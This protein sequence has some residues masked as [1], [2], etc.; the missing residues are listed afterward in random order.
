MAEFSMTI[1]AAAAATGAA[2]Q[3]S[4]RVVLLGIYFFLLFK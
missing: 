2:R 4:L 3:H 1:E